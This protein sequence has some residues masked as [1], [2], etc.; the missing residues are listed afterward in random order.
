MPH[1]MASRADGP[2]AAQWES[3]KKHPSGAALKWLSVVEKHGLD[4]LT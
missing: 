3:G 1:A 2:I 4:V